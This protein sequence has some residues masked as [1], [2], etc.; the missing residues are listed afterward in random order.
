MYNVSLSDKA[1]SFLRK[2]NSEKNVRFIINW[3]SELEENW[4]QSVWVKNIW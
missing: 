3:L 1:K 4:I 2:L